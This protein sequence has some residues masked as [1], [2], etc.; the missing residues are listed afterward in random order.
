MD[1]E[2]STKMKRGKLVLLE[3]NGVG[4]I[5]IEHTVNSVANDPITVTGTSGRQEYKVRGPHY[6]RLWQMRA[7]SAH[8]Y[9]LTFHGFSLIVHG[10]ITIIE[11]GT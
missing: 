5:G 2:Q 8:A 3:F 10:K 9:P 6:F 1:L 7:T 4:D 11:S